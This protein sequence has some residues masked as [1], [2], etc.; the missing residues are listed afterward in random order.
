M[1]HPKIK[2]ARDY[3][4]LK[5]LHCKIKGCADSL[6]VQPSWRKEYIYVAYDVLSL[7][8]EQIKKAI[9]DVEA[10]KHSGWL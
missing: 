6:Y 10:G 2:Y 3:C 5:G 1:E 8:E 4:K 7:S 9:D